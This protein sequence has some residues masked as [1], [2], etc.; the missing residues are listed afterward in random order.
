MGPSSLLHRNR[1]QFFQYLAASPLLTPA[2]SKLLAQ[3]APRI[4]PPLANAKD[5]IN[6]LDFEPLA[7]AK[8]PPAHWGYMA[9]GVDDDGTLRANR[10]GFQKI[11]IKP[12]RLVDVSKTDLRVDLFGTTWDSPIFVCPVGGQMMFHPDGE[13]AVARAAKA[14]KTLQIL[15]TQTTYSVEEVGKALGH[16]PWYQLYM[17]TK[18]ENTEKMVK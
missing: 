3:E 8:L 15:S 2:I 6:V 18:W 7:H 9:S 1:R 16:A 10:A 13:L 17:L 14:K 12:R 11:Q 5:A 4:P